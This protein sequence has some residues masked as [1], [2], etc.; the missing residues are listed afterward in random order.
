MNSDTTTSTVTGIISLTVSFVKMK[1]TKGL[2]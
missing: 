1:K 2:K